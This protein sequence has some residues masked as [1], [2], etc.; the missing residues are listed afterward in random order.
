MTESNY[1]TYVEGRAARFAEVEFIITQKASL[2]SVQIHR[3]H[4]FP[5]HRSQN[6]CDPPFGIHSD[7]VWFL[8][9][10]SEKPAKKTA[11]FDFESS[12]RLVQN[13]NRR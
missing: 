8:E 1:E 2:S 9:G 3:C 11:A 4:F 5:R 13:R 7:S 12:N 6:V 10:W